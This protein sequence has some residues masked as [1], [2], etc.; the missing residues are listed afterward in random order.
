MH[1]FFSNFIIFSTD[2][3]KK[4]QKKEKF[5]NFIIVNV[6]MKLAMKVVLFVNKDKLIVKK[7]NIFDVCSIKE[8]ENEQ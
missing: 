8:V 6:P 4:F 2:V 7:I 1:T 5:I 3:E